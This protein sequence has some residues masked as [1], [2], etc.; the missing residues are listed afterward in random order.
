MG[1]AGTAG[2]WAA[3]GAR[4]AGWETV[5][6]GWEEMAGGLAGACIPWGALWQP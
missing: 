2:G 3:A 6:A 4:E 1:K 5:G